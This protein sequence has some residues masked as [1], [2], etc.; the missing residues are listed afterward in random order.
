MARTT[1]NVYGTQGAKAAAYVA[2][3]GGDAVSAPNPHP[4]TPFA[5]YEARKPKR[6]R[7]Y[8]KGGALSL[9]DCVGA[10]ER[11]EYVFLLDRPCHPSW[12]RSMRY[13]VL[14]GMCRQGAVSEA[15]INP[16][17]IPTREEELPL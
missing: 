2:G 1:R 12:M 17:W 11:D 15:K 5:G 9:L 8:I 10:L 13:N 14:A 6:T 3:Y 4:R 16:D 7:K